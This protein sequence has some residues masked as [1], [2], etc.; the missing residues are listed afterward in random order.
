MSSFFSPS[1]MS[2]APEVVEMVPT[3]TSPEEDEPPLS[4]LTQ[5]DEETTKEMDTSGDD[6]S[7]NGSISSTETGSEVLE[8]IDTSNRGMEEYKVYENAKLMLMQTDEASTLGA[9]SIKVSGTLKLIQPKSNENRKDDP[10]GGCLPNC[11]VSIWGY[12][13]D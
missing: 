5:V 12:L 7:Q 2:S 1:L 9:P 10:V 6:N 11:L 13:F 3:M 8:E 4:A